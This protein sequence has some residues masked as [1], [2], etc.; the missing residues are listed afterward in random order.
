[1]V[2]KDSKRTLWRRMCDNMA[3]LIER[4]LETDG[5]HYWGITMYRTTYK[6]DVDWANFLDRFMGSVRTELES[7]DG[8]DILDSFRPVVMED[9]RR[10]DGATPD[11]IRDAFKEWA[12]VACETE[13]GVPY[14]R[15]EWAY[16]ARYRL[17]I[18]VDEEALQSVLDIPTEDLEAYNT[19][20]FV[21]L[22]NGRWPPEW[23][24]EELAAG[25]GPDD[26]HEPV[27]GCTLDEVGWMKV[28]YGEAQTGAS[29]RMTDDGDWSVEYRRP[30]A[31]GFHF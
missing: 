20:G 16:S 31:I 14:K 2:I 10:F 18:M 19:T 5:F 12:R 11:Q 1:M 21:I 13:Q 27:Y 26:G 22:I 7:D 30:P 23:D 29:S 25:G 3:D 28:R 17:C 8:L 9:A 6:S 24:P 4:N 15:A